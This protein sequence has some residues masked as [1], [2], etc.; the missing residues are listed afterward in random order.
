MG[1]NVQNIFR[2][3]AS[4]P[5]LLLGACSPRFPAFH[6]F[7]YCIDQRPFSNVASDLYYRD[8]KIGRSTIKL[9]S[10][11]Y[12]NVQIETLEAVPDDKENDEQESRFQTLK[13]LCRSTRKLKVYYDSGHT[14]SGGSLYRVQLQNSPFDH[15]LWASFGDE[16]DITKEKPSDFPTEGDKVDWDGPPKGEAEDDEENKYS[17]FHWVHENWPPDSDSWTPKDAPREWETGDEPQGWLAIDDGSMMIA[18][19]IYFYE[20]ENEDDKPVLSLIHVKGSESDSD[21]GNFLGQ[22]RGRHRAGGEEFTTPRNHEP[23]R[24]TERRSGYQGWN[25]RVEGWRSR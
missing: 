17:P 16:Y 10:S 25:V 4:F 7:G 14:L 6:E 18:N 19:F 15:F 12:T 1:L 8:N 5:G 9:D 13:R 23:R 20:P 24:G 22:L 3:T 21:E 11:D 2:V